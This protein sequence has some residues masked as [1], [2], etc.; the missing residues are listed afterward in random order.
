MESIKKIYLMVPTKGTFKKAHLM[1]LKLLLS[2]HVL[3]YACA[4]VQR[5]EK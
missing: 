4:M 3:I 2:I 5:E 1:F